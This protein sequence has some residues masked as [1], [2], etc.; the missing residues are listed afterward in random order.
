MKS[1]TN[2]RSVNLSDNQVVCVYMF[3]FH[4]VQTWTIHIYI[5]RGS[6]HYVDFAVF[7]TEKRYIGSSPDSMELAIKNHWS[8]V[9]TENREI[10][11]ETYSSNSYA[12]QRAYLLYLAHHK[13]IVAHTH[14]GTRVIRMLER[15]KSY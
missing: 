7:P 12:I 1:C 3:V 4:S 8:H 9:Y 6:D 13:R 10:A 15:Y 2:H 11:H 5:K 14:I